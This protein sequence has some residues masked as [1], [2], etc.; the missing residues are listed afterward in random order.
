MWTVLEGEA[1]L[2][3]DILVDQLRRELGCAADSRVDYQCLSSC[4]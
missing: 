2:K 1:I 4:Q 3:G